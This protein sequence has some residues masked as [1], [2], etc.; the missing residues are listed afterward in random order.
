MPSPRWRKILRDLG[1]NKTRTVLVVLSI[2]IGVFAIGVV[3]GSQVILSHDLTASYLAINPANASFYTDSFDDNQV[4]VIRGMEG[5]DYAEGVRNFTVRIKFNPAGAQSK[6]AEPQ[7]AAAQDVNLRLYVIP[8]FHDIR[9]N[10]IE[11]TRGEWPPPRHEL[12][13]ERMSL[14]LT[15]SQVGDRLT[16]ELPDGKQR[17]LQ[18][19]GL[20]HD[21]NEDPAA[22]TGRAIGYVTLDTAEWLEQPRTYNQLNITVSDDKLNAVHIRQVADQVRDKIE[23]GGRRVYWVYVPIPGKHP[24]DSE[25][26][27]LLLLLGALGLLSVFASG[28]LIVNTISAILGQQVRQIGVMKAI[29]GRASQIGVMYLGMVFVFSLLALAL[30]V[31]LAEVGAHALVSYLAN[32]LNTDI[33]SFDLPWQVIALQVIV[34]LVVPFVAALFPVVRGTRL[35]VREA[36]SD[37]GLRAQPPKGLIDRVIDHIHGVS[38]PLLLSL[39]NT[40][41]RQARLALTLLTLTLGGAIFIA[42]MSVRSSLL[43]TVDDAFHFWGYDV[44]IDFG[45]IYRTELIQQESFA[46]P[47]VVGVENWSSAGVRRV[48][49]DG[50]TSD[51]LFVNGV[52]VPSE[53]IHPSVTQGRWLL[54]EDENA[55][56]VNADVLKNEKDIQVGS[57][58]VLRLETEETH[59]RVVGLIKSSLSGARLFAN[60]AYASRIFH[61]TGR[62]GAVLVIARDRE[63]STANQVSQALQDRFKKDGIRMSSVG[64]IA[65]QRRRANSQV[66]II[67]VFLMIMAVLLALVGG[68]GLMGTMSLNVVERTREIGVLRAIGASDGSVL[69]IVIVEGVLIGVLSWMAG[70]VLSLPLGKILSDQVGAAFLNDELN[71]SFSIAG[72]ATWLVFVILLAAVA[73]FLP[74]RGAS[75]L[76]VREVLAYE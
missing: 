75:R 21:I 24:A 67:V 13:I 48:R 6:P 49:P 11:P 4:E 40:F 15:R 39:R 53:V 61:M 32:L 1:T 2:A 41:R 63:A 22:F 70:A 46:V 43:T 55:I 59:W 54:P 62:S 30:A 45:R 27:T 16:I 33:R 10:K 3:A 65:D 8:D 35:T 5:I 57:D 12:L 56:V 34:G 42:V 64:T 51:N 38:R 58:I 73:S 68:L 14:G 28:F 7:G 76:S 18:I 23:R 20:A 25:I 72:A 44:E 31:P 50:T 17:E 9:I 37:Y 60:Y 36:I 29:G 26:Q 71:Y 47:G 66:D 19:A 69:S 52:P 74:A